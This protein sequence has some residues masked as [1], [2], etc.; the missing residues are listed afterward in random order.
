M[1]DRRKDHETRRTIDETSRLLDLPIIHYKNKVKYITRKD[2]M[3]YAKILLVNW[4]KDLSREL[5]RATTVLLDK[6]D[7]R[8]SMGFTGSIYE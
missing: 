7:K 8:R 5:A 1:N 4:D 2:I 6:D 3:H